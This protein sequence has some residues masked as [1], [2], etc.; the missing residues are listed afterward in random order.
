MNEQEFLWEKL[1]NAIE[2]NAILKQENQKLMK[3]RDEAY[4]RWE[5]LNKEIEERVG[6]ILVQRIYDP[7]NF[8]DRLNIIVDYDPYLYRASDFN[9]EIEVIKEVAKTFQTAF[10][11]HLSGKR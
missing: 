9:M 7:N 4:A 6:N 3:S 11:S 1:Q 5:N 8:Q 2:E 10:K